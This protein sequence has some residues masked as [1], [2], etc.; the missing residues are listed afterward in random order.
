MVSLVIRATSASGIFQSV[1]SQEVT[2]LQVTSTVGG[3]QP[4]MIGHAF[5]KGDVPSGSDIVS[6]TSGVSLASVV[7]RRW[8]D[9]SV[10]HAILCGLADTTANV[11]KTISVGIGETSVGT[12]LTSADITAAA[13]TAT[14]QLG[15]LGTASLASLLSSPFRT[16]ISTPQMVE[17]HYRAAITSALVVWFHVRLWAGGRMWIRAFVENGYI[18]SSATVQNY[19]PT[20]TI[21]GSTVYTFADKSITSI[22]AETANGLWRYTISTSAAHGLGTNQALSLS[23]VGGMTVLNGRTTYAETVIDSDTFRTPYINT[24]NPGSFTSGGTVSFAHCPWTRYDVEGWIGVNPGLTPSHNTTYLGTTKLV[25]N[26]WKRNPSASVLNGL[27]Q[28][29]IPTSRGSYPADTSG[30]GFGLFIGPLQQ[31]DALYCTSADIRAYRACLAQ[32]RA[33][34]S[35]SLF[36]KN[37]STNRIPRPSDFPTTTYAG[38]GNGSETIS[39]DAV[40]WDVSHAPNSGYLAYLITGDYYFY[41][42]MGHTAQSWY[43][44]RS[45][46]GGTGVNKNLRGIQNRGVAWGLRTVGNFCAIAPNENESAQDTPILTDY[47]SWLTNLYTDFVNEKNLAGQNQLGII[48]SFSVGTDW[49]DGINGGLPTWMT[50]F[51]VGVNGWLSEIDPISVLTNLIEVRDWM[52]RWT[53]GTMGPTGVSNY[54]FTRASNYGVVVDPTATGTEF[55]PDERDFYDSW[56]DVWTA[57][58]G[59]PNNETTNTLQGASGGAPNNAPTGYWGNMMP[60]LAYAVDHSATGASAALSRYI[61]ASNF[62]TIENS[63]FDDIPIWGIVPRTVAMS[64]APST[65]LATM[66]ASLGAGQSRF[67]GTVPAALLNIDGNG[68]SLLQYA[69]SGVYDPIRKEA[70]FIG[71]RSSNGAPYRWLLYDEVNN[72]WSITSRAVHPSMQSNQNGH[73]YDHHTI[74]PVTGIHYVKQYDSNVVHVWN[75]SWQADTTAMTNECDAATIT[76]HPTLGIFYA[77]T[78]ICRTY[79]GGVWT[80]RATLTAGLAQNHTVS[81]YNTVSNILIFGSGNNDGTM[82]KITSA[83]VVSTIATPPFNVG[84]SESQGLLAEDPTGRGFIGRDKNTGSWTFYNPDTDAWSS[85]TQSTGSG[86]SPQN[87]LPNLASGGTTV[88]SLSITIPQYNCIMYIQ[89]AGSAVGANVWLYRHT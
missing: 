8:N 48:Y 55:G 35:F 42:T 6:S 72:T 60:A 26:Y 53:V 16:W 27:N 83:G 81:A 73:G 62:S 74:D 64:P 77:D 19:V 57:T 51:H 58:H 41:E 50:N 54:H 37:S 43:F 85:L 17:C 34:N 66:A 70:G 69:S 87:G 40:T 22:T 4:F 33:S 84:S 78:R 68:F 25:P 31:W 75:G 80:D 47:Q 38:G 59:S 71:K 45:T 15:A 7:K 82:R 76:W 86:A 5:K 23:G 79:S 3:N 1:A 21:G 24:G 49:T 2:T 46:S 11:A 44:A 28:T 36:R 39:N 20:I 61:N 29:Y 89:Y 14:V 10:K 30:T 65:T 67:F 63:G 52:Y 56:G 13:P 12:L 18:Q 9:G 88:H 32:V